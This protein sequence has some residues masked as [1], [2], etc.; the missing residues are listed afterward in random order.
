MAKEDTEQSPWTRP[1]F[2]AA[3]VVVAIVLVLAVVLG[4]GA[5]NREPDPG[6]TSAATSEPSTG[7]SASS[8]PDVET[9][10]Q[11]SACGLEGFEESGTVTAAPEADWSYVGTI[12]V[13]GSSSSGPAAVEGGVR[14]CFAHTPEGALFASVNAAAQGS[15][16]TT[17]VAWAEYAFA[18]GA[19]RELA[20]ESA[21]TAGV[22][23]GRLQI[24]GFR[25]LGYA[26]DQA[27]V[28]VAVRVSSNEG[29]VLLSAVYE[30]V[31]EDGDWK[32][33]TTEGGGLPFQPSPIPD[34]TGYTGWSEE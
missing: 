20:I 27:T 30:L 34:L 33:V 22:S 9:G 2:V 6:P 24:A 29:A 32:V 17:R 14:R 3:T 21:R 10:D 25:I 15:D 12:G 11:S 16:P 8:S 28:D 13:P 23:D 18:S 26:A 7:P 19:G 1:G 31:W 5:M 4:I